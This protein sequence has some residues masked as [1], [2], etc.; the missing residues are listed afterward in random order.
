MIAGVPNESLG[1]S[2]CSLCNAAHANLVEQCI[3][4]CVGLLFERRRLW[5]EL[6]CIDGNVHAVPRIT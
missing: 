3:H 2:L 5:F 4:D 6:S 1:P